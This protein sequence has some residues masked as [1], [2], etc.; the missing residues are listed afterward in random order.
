MGR[1]RRLRRLKRIWLADVSDLL[2]RSDAVVV[3]L[4]AERVA[5]RRTVAGLEAALAVTTEQRDLCMDAASPGL[6]ERLRGS[7]GIVGGG[8]LYGSAWATYS[9]HKAGQPIGEVPTVTRSEADAAR[10]NAAI[11]VGLLAGG[12]AVTAASFLL[13]RRK[14]H[15]PALAVVPVDD[16]GL[17][18]IAFT[19]EAP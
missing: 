7:L 3:A 14:D 6:L 8:I 13:P 12:V 9:A 5:L 15:G 4:Q 19:L 1:V 11:G 18:L 17:L 10:R 16:G 2:A